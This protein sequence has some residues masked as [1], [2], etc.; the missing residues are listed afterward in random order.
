MII[1]TVRGGASA[2]I[3]TDVVQ[4]FVYVAGAAVVFFSLLALIPAGWSE[5]ARAGAAA[6]KFRVFDLSLVLSRPCTLW[7]GIVGGVALTLSTHGTGSVPG[8]AS[9]G[10]AHAARSGPRA[11][12]RAAFSSS[13]SS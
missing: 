5:V 11:G 8:A 3:W 6:G 10:G 1:Y 4:L 7:A 13:P 12:A 9:A 2:V